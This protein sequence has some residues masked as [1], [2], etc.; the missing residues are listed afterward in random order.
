MNKLLLVFVFALTLAGCGEVSVDPITVNGCF[1]GEQWSNFKE[2]CQGTEP[3]DPNNPQPGE[4][5]ADMCRAVKI[6]FTCDDPGAASL[7][8]DVVANP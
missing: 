1:S 7:S 6:D 4:F 3:I 5:N 8:G 2:Y